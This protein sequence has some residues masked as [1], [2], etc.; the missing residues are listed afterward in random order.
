MKGIAEKLKQNLKIVKE[1][2]QK[3]LR[4]D[5]QLHANRNKRIKRKLNDGEI[6]K[7]S[8]IRVPK[9]KA[10]YQ[11]LQQ[12]KENKNRRKNLDLISILKF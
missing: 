9:P 2:K 10:E 3:Q 6:Q 7:N 4:S 1:V 11:K 5:L 8:P 12:K